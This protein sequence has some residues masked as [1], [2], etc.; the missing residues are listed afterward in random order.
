MPARR[1]ASRE[2]LSRPFPARIGERDQMP[3]QIAAV[4]GGDISRIERAQ[5]ARVVPVVEMTAEAREAGS[6]SRASPPAARPPRS[7]PIQPKSRA[8]TTERR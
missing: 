4:D 8:L 6:S 7:F 3:G 2:R 1:C 5:I